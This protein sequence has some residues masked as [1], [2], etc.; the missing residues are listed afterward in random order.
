ML[1]GQP[2]FTGP[3][4]MA[5]LA[6]HSL[7][8]VPSLQIVRHSIPEGVELVV[9]R[10][11]EKVAADRYHTMTEFAEAL[12]AAELERISVRTGARAVPTRELPVSRPKPRRRAWVLGAAGAALALVAGPLA[13]Y[14]W[15]S[16]RTA[17]SVT[18]AGGLDPHHVAV[19]YFEDLRGQD[20][21]RYLADGLTEGL[22]RELGQVPSLTVISRNG[23][24]P[25]RSDSIPRDSIARALKVGT[26][27]LGSMEQDA[28]RLRVTVRLVDGASGADFQRASFEQAATN[29]LAVQDTLTHQ[30]ASLIRQRL[31]EEIKLRGLRE[32]TASPQAWALVQRAEQVRKQGEALVARQDTDGAARSFDRADSLYAQAQAEDP[33]WVEPLIGRGS[34]AYRRSRLG[35]FDPLAAKPWI[36]KGQKFADDALALAPQDPDALEL[37]GTLRYWSWLV[38]LEADPVAARTLLSN[39]QSDL[40]ASVRSHPSQAGAWAAL[41]HLY[42]QNHAAGQIEAKLAAQRAYEADAYLNNADQI[43]WRLFVSSYDLGQFIDAVRWCEEGQRRF[44]ADYKFVK[45]PLFLMT[46]KA[47]EPDVA[48]AWTLADSV[49][50][51]APAPR[52]EFEK[53]EGQMLVAIV[54]ARSGLLDSARQV[55]QRSRGNPDVDPT[56]DLMLDEAY[57]HL[58]L[59]ERDE[60]LKALKAY[61]AANPDRR[62]GMADDPGWW[63]RGLQDD[64][65]FQQMVRGK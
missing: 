48:L 19:L 33:K 32:G 21:L 47:R 7:E 29:V 25:Y 62:A 42:N 36:E 35:G 28:G 51:V 14:I 57:L 45:C 3:T 58:L 11:L 44:P 5:V 46:S 50:K 18:A 54:L 10:A 27:V 61:L 55:S 24:A 56:R 34:M 38:R 30:V 2:P 4:P 9:L 17:R 20:S 13:W 63:F 31:G 12:R 43:L 16:H 39:A 1:A 65:R 37:R 49:A 23:V 41:S 53:L 8:R 6:R 52:R 60:A 22:I 15:G 40:E 59:G 64:P 26:L